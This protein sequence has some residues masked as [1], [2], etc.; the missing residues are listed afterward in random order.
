MSV[1]FFLSL[2]WI[3]TISVTYGDWGWKRVLQSVTHL[4]WLRAA[5]EDDILDQA[6]TSIGQ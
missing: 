3:S 5:A 2:P 6:S 4:S 1:A